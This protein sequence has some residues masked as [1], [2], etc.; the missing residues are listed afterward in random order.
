MK[1]KCENSSKSTIYFRHQKPYIPVV[2]YKYCVTSVVKLNS[3]L[4][5]SA[6]FNIL[7]A[8]RVI[9]QARIQ[10]A[11]YRRYSPRYSAGYLLDSICCKS[12]DH[13][14]SKVKDSTRGPAAEQCDLSG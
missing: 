4:K 7:V 9:Q 8:A 14:C 13:G 2:R 6:K 11:I 3:W 10:D 12:P 1:M 5:I